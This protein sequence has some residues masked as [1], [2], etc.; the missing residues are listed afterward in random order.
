M[1][2]LGVGVKKGVSWSGAGGVRR[3]REDELSVFKP[4]NLVLC[5]IEL[6]DVMDE[7][8]LLGE[9]FQ[10]ND[11]RPRGAVQVTFVV[12]ERAAQRADKLAGKSGR[13]GVELV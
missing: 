1:V 6:I 4:G 8:V 10:V 7:Q 12:E 13:P 11:Q 3:E 5:G 2:V 9:F